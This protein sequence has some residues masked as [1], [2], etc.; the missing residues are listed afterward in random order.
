[1]AAATSRYQCPTTSSPT[2]GVK[3]KPSAQPMMSCPV[4]RPPFGETRSASRNFPRAIASKGPSIQGRGA[5]TALKSAPPAPQI[6]S[7]LRAGW[8]F[9]QDWI[10]FIFRRKT[11]RRFD[12]AGHPPKPVD[13]GP[14]RCG[15]A[16]TCVNHQKQRVGA[17]DRLPGARDSNCFD[18]VRSVTQTGGVDDIHGHALDLNDLAHRVARCAGNF[19]DDCEVLPGEPVEKRRFS[20]VGLTSQYDLKSAAKH[21]ALTAAGERTAHLPL[22]M[23]QAPAGLPSIHLI[24][25][26]LGKI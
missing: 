21:A 23:S 7:A 1:M 18:R 3:Y 8:G 16:A 26:L 9:M 22:Q 10:R 19:G 12:R 25:F 15:N 6:T 13:D 2:V 4:A 14:I 20:Y 17:P 5:C 11:A 24:D